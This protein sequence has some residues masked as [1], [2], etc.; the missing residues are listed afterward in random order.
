[1]QNNTDAVASANLVL[2]PAGG[3]STFVDLIVGVVIIF[4]LLGIL[5]LVGRRRQAK[6]RERARANA[7]SR[8]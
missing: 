7:Q 3:A 1:L 6:A 8:R 4:A 2:L 5:A